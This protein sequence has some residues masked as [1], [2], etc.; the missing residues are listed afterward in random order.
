MAFPGKMAHTHN[1][2]T[3]SLTFMQHKT[4]KIDLNLKL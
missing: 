2:K 1:N 3:Q 4:Q